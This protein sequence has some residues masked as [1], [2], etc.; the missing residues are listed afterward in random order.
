[1]I[2]MVQHRFVDCN[3][4][5]ALCMMLTLEEAVHVGP[6]SI[7]KLSVPLIQTYCEPKI[8]LKNKASF[9]KW[10]EEHSRI[11]E[12]FQVSCYTKGSF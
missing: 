9:K 10:V 12:S 1:M 11:L 5:T 3:T 4:C 2:M 6:G 8:A 7:R